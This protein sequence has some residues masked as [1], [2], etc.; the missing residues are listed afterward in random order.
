MK[1][2]TTLLLG[3]F[4]L[5]PAPLVAEEF[6]QWTD[7]GGV[8]HFTDNLTSV[9]ES[10]R[11][12]PQLVVRKDSDLKGNLSEFPANPLGP[13]DLVQEPAPAEPEAARIPQPVIHQSEITQIIVVNQGG[14]RRFKKRPH[15]PSVGHRPAFRPDFNNRRYVH[16]SVFDKGGSR[17][18]IQPDAFQPRP[19]RGRITGRGG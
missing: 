12:S 7:S 11:N 19:R 2:K 8:I 13:Q 3:L 6:Y 4:L 10:L 15:R 17:Q 5:S 16:P 1:A 18:Y 9:P 14:R